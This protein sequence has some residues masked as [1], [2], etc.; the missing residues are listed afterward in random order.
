MSAQNRVKIS[1]RQLATFIRGAKSGLGP[2]VSEEEIVRAMLV[3][4]STP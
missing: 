3:V 4:R 1:E 2:E